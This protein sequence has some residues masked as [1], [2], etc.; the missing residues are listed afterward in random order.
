MKIAIVYDRV[1]K[2]GGAERV[3]L[4]LHKMFPEAVLY[5][6]VYDSEKASW[7][8][9]FPKV[10]TSFL[11]KVPFA[12]SRH[13][14]FAPLMPFVFES[15]DFSDYDLVIS[16]T[17]EAAKAIITK[18]GTLHVCYCLTPTRYLWS[19]YRDYFAGRLLRVIS[20][21]VVGYLRDWDKVVSQRPDVLIGISTAV[22]ERIKKYYGRDSE[23][24]FPPAGLTKAAFKEHVN[25]KYFLI[26]SR[27]VTYKKVDLAIK[28]FNKL[29]LPLII[30][31][32]GS[33]EKRLKKLA[34]KNIK[35][36]G[37]VTDEELIKYYQGAKSLIMPQKEDFGLVAVEAQSFGVPVIAFKNGGAV[38]TVIDGKTGLLF[39]NQTVRS[40]E[41]AVKKF[42][43]WHFNK[44]ELVT[45]AARFSSR[46][47]QESFIR[48]CFGRRRRNQTLA[49]VPQ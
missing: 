27:L 12:K 28:V 29:N 31:G 45:N 17:S 21:K 18:P 8:K 37:Q 16:V 22:K 41:N 30:V 26:V 34:A 23:V 42:D 15:F 49:K 36:A 46:R 4:S 13:E 10:I 32:A 20:N 25:K 6:S 9:V 40:L 48:A 39:E 5:T 2:W 11:Q 7:A 44:E 33:E 47:F 43:K 1:N 14:L 19:G 38:D 24:I 35:F 3:L